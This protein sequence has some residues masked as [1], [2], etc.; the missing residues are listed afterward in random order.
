MT[1]LLGPD[2]PDTAGTMY[3]LAISVEQLGRL[4]EAADLFRGAQQ[5]YV[6]VYGPDHEETLDAGRKA[7]ACEGG[8]GGDD[9]GGAGDGDGEEVVAVTT[10]N[11]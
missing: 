6:H 1:R 10:S 3:K 8:G 11:L 4:A 9:G 7:Q 5:V 2:H